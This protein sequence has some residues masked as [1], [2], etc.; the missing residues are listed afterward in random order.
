M[1]V[2]QRA[3]DDVYS[4]LASSALAS[5]STVERNVRSRLS[6]LCAFAT[7]SLTWWATP[8]RRR[9]LRSSKPLSSSSSRTTMQPRRSSSSRSGATAIRPRASSGVSPVGNCGRVELERLVGIERAASL[10]VRRRRMLLQDGRVARLVAVERAHGE[11]L[12]GAVLQPDGRARLLQEP[13]G[14]V[15]RALEHLVERLGERPGD[16]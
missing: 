15:D 10:L 13:G 12:A 16:G 1:S 6:K 11:V 3:W 8:A 5:A 9:M 7:A 2:I 4:S 14:Q